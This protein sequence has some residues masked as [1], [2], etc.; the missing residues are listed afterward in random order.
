MRTNTSPGPMF[1][2]V[3]GTGHVSTRTS[4]TPRYT[5][6]R[7]V[8]GIVGIVHNRLRADLRRMIVS[9]LILSTLILPR[10]RSFSQLISPR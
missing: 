1:I 4:L 8:A 5:A 3:T 9:A 2:G 6:A 10:A 7:I